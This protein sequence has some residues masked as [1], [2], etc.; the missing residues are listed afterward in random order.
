MAV[1]LENACLAHRESIQALSDRVLASNVLKRISALME[2]RY[3]V[4][5]GHTRYISEGIVVK[6]TAVELFRANKAKH[7]A[8]HVQLD[9]IAQLQKK[10]RFLARRG[11]NNR[12]SRRKEC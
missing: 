2:R 10:T 11:S 5:L 4:L 1:L 7:P 6:L 9:H 8:I 3:L 12:D